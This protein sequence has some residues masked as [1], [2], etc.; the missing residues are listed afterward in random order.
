MI[1]YVPQ[2]QMTQLPMWHAD[3]SP[4]NDLDETE[5]EIDEDQPLPDEVLE[6]LT[7]EADVPAAVPDPGPM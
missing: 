4:L 6:N 5:S 7:E 1:P 3:E 2:P